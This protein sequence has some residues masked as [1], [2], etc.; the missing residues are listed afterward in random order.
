MQSASPDY[1]PAEDSSAAR[2]RVHSSY[3]IGNFIRD[4]DLTETVSITIFVPTRVLPQHVLRDA[5][6]LGT[7]IYEQFKRTY[8]DIMGLLSCVR[9]KLLRNNGVL[10]EFSFGGPKLW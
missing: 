10:L 6:T 9:G 4:H 2:A 7:S 5:D 1:H 3:D 8:S